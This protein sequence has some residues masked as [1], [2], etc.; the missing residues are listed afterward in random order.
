MWIIAT[1]LGIAAGIGVYL[2]VSATG[3]FLRRWWQQRQQRSLASFIAG[4]TQA[5]IV[6]DTPELWVPGKTL[7]TILVG[8]AL[9]AI[10]IS[11]HGGILIGIGLLVSGVFTLLYSRKR[12]ALERQAQLTN[13]VE[14]LLSEYYSRWLLNAS[15]FGILEDIAA[16]ISFGQ[17]LDNILQQV[18]SR[19]R[20]GEPDALAPLRGTDPYLQQFGY[21]LAQTARAGNQVTGEAVNEV[22]K[23]LQMR[24]RLQKRVGTVTAMTRGEELFLLVA[25]AT[26]VV[27]AIALPLLREFYTS[28]LVRQL[29]LALAI[30]IVTV[31]GVYF[32]HEI[33][34]L[35]E[36]AL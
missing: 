16:D 25:N 11:W 35:K 10:Y 24:H 33:E 28:S 29:V 15:P 2:P 27:V 26:A 7:L 12:N 18:L 4:T 36:K 3:D 1:T 31:G 23:R 13:Q 21:I 32:D 8:E 20:L 5:E 22:S 9:V 19:Y 30:V 17:P 34:T 14:E 6:T